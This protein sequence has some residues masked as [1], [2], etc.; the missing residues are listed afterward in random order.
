MPDTESESPIR[1]THFCGATPE[2]DSIGRCVLGRELGIAD[3]KLPII[4][5]NA[6]ETKGKPTK[7]VLLLQ[8]REIREHLKQPANL[9]VIVTSQNALSCL[10]KPESSVLQSRLF[11]L[12]KVGSIYFVYRNGC[13]ISTLRH[14]LQHNIM[15]EAFDPAVATELTE[16][17][18]RRKADAEK[19]LRAF[20]DLKNRLTETP[21][22]VFQVAADAVS[23]APETDFI[24]ELDALVTALPVSVRHLVSSALEFDR[25]LTYKEWKQTDEFRG[26]KVLRG[27]NWT[28]AGAKPT[29]YFDRYW[30]D[31]S[32]ELKDIHVRD[33]DLY[34]AVKAIESDHPG[35]IIELRSHL[36]SFAA[37]R[38]A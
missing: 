3:G 28:C 26:I 35:Y 4:D 37:K 9:C 6:P 20:G 21:D 36:T 33:K 14:N 16:S 11:D 25:I 38:V 22:T 31:F 24:A 7:Q 34:I 5:L 8:L 10:W 32:G 12:S 19:T 18:K 13:K 2:F 30:S 27:D 23:S 15:P 1:I 17:A 29:K